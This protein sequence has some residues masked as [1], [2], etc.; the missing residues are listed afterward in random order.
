MKMLKCRGVYISCLS[1]ST[2]IGPISLVQLA[3][4][5]LGGRIVSVF[6]TILFDFPPDLNQTWPIHRRHFCA[7][8][9]KLS[10]VGKLILC[11]FLPRIKM[12]VCWIVCCAV[13]IIYKELRVLSDSHKKYGAAPKFCCMGNKILIGG[14]LA[15]AIIF[16]KKVEG[17]VALTILTMSAKQV[18]VLTFSLNLT[19]SKLIIRIIVLLPIDWHCIVS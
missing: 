11:S 1:Y 13:L 8:N 7:P 17:L 14:N 5:S 16:T 4:F 10:P 2:I 3:S 9:V 18:T 19:N 6:W 15:L 12:C